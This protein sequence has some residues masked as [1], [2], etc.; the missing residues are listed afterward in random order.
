LESP[1]ADRWPEISARLDEALDLNPDARSVW[2]ADLATRE[3]AIAAQVRACLA[4]LEHLD[5]QDFLG[6]PAS[7]V[8]DASLAGLRFGAYTLERQIGSGGTGTV[9]LARR[10]DGRFEGEAAVKLLNPALVGH[11]SARRFAR[12]G[13]V[14]A[15]LRHPHIAHLM[16]AGVGAG[17]QPYLILE[18]VSGKPIDQYCEERQLNV[19]QRVRL[20]LDVLSALAH[21]HNNLIVHRDLKPSNILV[22]GEGVVKLLDFGVA[23]LLSPSVEKPTNVTRHVSPGLTPGYAAP[24]QLAGDSVTTAS[25][26]YALGSVLFLLLAGRHPLG[27]DEVST[28]ELMRMTLDTDVPRASEAAIDANRARALRGDLDNII[29]MAVRR[30]PAE[31]YASAELLAQ[32]LRRHLAFEPVVARP[33]SVLYLTR[34]FMRRHRGAVAAASTIAAILVSAV[35]LTTGQ[36]LEAREQRDRAIFESRQAEATKDFL[37]QLMMTDLGPN[38]PMH[39]FYERLETG[40]KVLEQ[41]YRDDP[42]FKGRMLAELGAGFTANENPL[43]ANELYQKAYE[44]GRAEQD[45]ELMIRA[46]CSRVYGDAYADID[47]GVDERLKEVEQLLARLEKP[48]AEL[49]VGCLMARSIVERRRGRHDEAEALLLRARRIMEDSRDTHRE[50]YTNVLNE[51]GAQYIARNRPQDMLRMMQLIG[52]IH[53]RNGRGATS[54]RLA[55]RQNAATALNAMGE[56]RAALAEREIINRRLAEMAGPDEEPPVI[57]V[58]YAAV[59]LR[60]RQPAAALEVLDQV[61]DKIRSAGNAGSLANA[62]ANKGSALLMLNRLDEAE[63][64]FREAASIAASGIGN[65]SLGAQVAAISGRLELA[66]GNLDGARRYRDQALELAGYRKE[67]PQR[68]LMRVLYIAAEVALAEGA[69]AYAEQFARDALAIAEP[70]ARTPDSSGDVGEALLRIA[71]ARVASGAREDARPILDRAIRCLTNGFG[72]EHPLTVQ[73]RMLRNQVQAD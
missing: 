24:E 55:T 38:H 2:L 13:S 73:A 30:N 5:Q 26:V 71:E 6:T 11:P 67:K 44:I 62:L 47:E 37:Q 49:Q 53:D 60:M 16:D 52:E 51:L 9:W 3:P 32:D 63:L 39:T 59:L 41:E 57:R 72:P 42:R 33:R 17:N 1:L 12:E 21:A 65:R 70:N 58:N 54:N 35:V 43:R 68:S 19:E 23:A 50:M 4:A 56:T 27:G 45:A 46:Q 34:R 36:M 20:F 25:D 61:L 14:L 69:A 29:A 10:S 22:T 8:L 31:R 64:A 28:A 66:R 18:Y 15:R 48:D 7:S 40:V